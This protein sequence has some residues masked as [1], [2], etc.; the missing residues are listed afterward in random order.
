MTRL[1]ERVHLVG[2]VDH[3]HDLDC[4]V[5]LVDGGGEL[6]L[7]DAG[8]GRAAAVI[9]ENVR[10]AGYDPGAIRHLLLTHGHGDHAAGAAALAALL[11]GVRVHAS[12]PVRRWLAEGDDAAVSIDVARAAGMYPPDFTLEPCTADG[13]LA[14]GG[15]VR[16]GE[17][18][19]EVLD[20]PG[21]CAG[22]VSLV[23]DDGGR[24]DLLAGDAVF[25][26]GRVALQPIYDCSLAEQVTT[27]RMLRGLEVDG[28]LAGHGEPVLADAR[29]H[30]AHANAALDELRIPEPLLPPRAWAAPP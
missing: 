1:T 13:E 14:G 25:A 11:D 29:T 27:L 17:L 30:I 19:L 23:V 16:V 28:L 8:G 15:T 2:G 3:S 4:H 12:A 26:G 5:Y 6:A 20:T 24:R 18:E 22:H 21:H 10:V 9:V 7:V